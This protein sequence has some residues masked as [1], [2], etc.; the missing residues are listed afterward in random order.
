MSITQL[1]HIYGEIAVLAQVNYL[2]DYI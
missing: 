2:N 1:Q